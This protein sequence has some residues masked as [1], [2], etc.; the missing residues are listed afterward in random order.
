MLSLKMMEQIQFLHHAAYG[1]NIFVSEKPTRNTSI[2]KNNIPKNDYS[3][4]FKKWPSHIDE[5]ETQ[6]ES[7]LNNWKYN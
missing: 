5:I 2:N 6:R 7:I 1:L 3:Y 4:I